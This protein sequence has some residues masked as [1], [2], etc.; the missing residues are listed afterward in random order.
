MRLSYSYSKDCEN[1]FDSLE[2]GVGTYAV[3]SY[4]VE[5]VWVGRQVAASGRSDRKSNDDG[6]D[7]KDDE[8]DGLHCG[9]GG[10]NGEVRSG[11]EKKTKSGE[12]YEF[13]L[14]GVTWSMSRMRCKCF[15]QFRA[16]IGSKN[17]NASVRAPA[18]PA[19]SLSL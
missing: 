17:R 8:S 10:S 18:R 6:E 9:C 11:L 15:M 1:F 3:A 13:G 16:A 7:G 19:H 5:I 12:L 2:T 4:S 14:C